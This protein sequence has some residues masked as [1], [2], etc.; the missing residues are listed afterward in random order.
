MRLRSEQEV[1]VSRDPW[2]GASELRERTHTV[3][4]LNGRSVES[5][6]SREVN[7][8]SCGCVDRPA[9]SYCSSCHATS[10]RHCTTNCRRCRRPLCLA[11]THT[12]NVV[13]GGEQSFCARCRRYERI[14]LIFVLSVRGFLSLLRA[15][16]SPF[17]SFRK[18]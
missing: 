1:H 15:L 6:T 18:S 12:L 16:L 9:A 7:P 3:H 13:E 2:D 17:I 14:R 11:C 10:C 4:E 8:A 5:F